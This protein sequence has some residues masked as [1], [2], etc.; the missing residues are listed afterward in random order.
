MLCIIYTN[1]DRVASKANAKHI[2][3]VWHAFRTETGNEPWVFPSSQLPS[4]CSTYS[5]IYCRLNMPLKGS[6]Y[7]KC[8]LQLGWARPL[9]ATVHDFAHLKLHSPSL[10]KAL[11]TTSRV[12]DIACLFWFGIK[13]LSY[14]I[15]TVPWNFTL[16]D[17]YI[18]T[19][20]QSTS[21][22][23]QPLNHHV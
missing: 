17:R 15:G 2:L 18:S 8:S 10:I 13:R 7:N 19:F 14:F 20:F 12:H 23:H 9:N 16:K 6:R 5:M 22:L 1:W 21:K 11:H 4:A 3:C